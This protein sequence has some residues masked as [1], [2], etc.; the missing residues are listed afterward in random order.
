MTSFGSRAIAAAA[1][2][3]TV[4]FGTLQLGVGA[5]DATPVAGMGGLPNHIHSGTCE[6]LGEVVVP[7]ANLEF[8]PMAGN[9]MMAATPAAGGMA[10]TPGAGAMATPMMGMAAVAIPVA[11]A[12]TDV[13]LP[14]A[15]ILAAPHAINVHSA[16]DISLYV[17]CGD[18]AG[19][20]DEQGNL[21]IGLAEQNGSGLNGV[22]WLL[23]DGE[24][25]IVTVFL[26]GGTGMMG[27]GMGGMMATPAS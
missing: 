11:V 19:T 20:P 6:S 1:L 9:G 23:A 26:S 16:E 7:L 4:A 18:I 13:P 21:F 2:A 8:R 15:D 27:A 25:T 10:A 22:A 5:Q 3:G 17:A 24:Q 14:L 12:T